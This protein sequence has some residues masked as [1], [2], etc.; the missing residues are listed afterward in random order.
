RS[1]LRGGRSIGRLPGL[2]GGGGLGARIVVA[3]GKEDDRAGRGGERALH[4]VA[5]VRAAGGAAPPCNTP[6]CD[7]VLCR[8]A[9]SGLPSRS[10]WISR[11]PTW[12]AGPTKPSASIRSI[13]FAAVL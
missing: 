5:P 6:A 12:L 9:Q 8:Q 11:R 7:A 4:G 3:P 1:R 10:R 2:F 13:H